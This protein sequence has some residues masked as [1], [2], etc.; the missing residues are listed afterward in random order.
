MRINRCKRQIKSRD[1]EIE[2]PN[3]ANKDQEVK[4][5]ESRA[6]QVTHVPREEQRNANIVEL[7]LMVQI[8]LDEPQELSKEQPI[9]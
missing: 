3:H 6:R 5:D 1:E 2:E 7:D 9:I 8:T 4:S